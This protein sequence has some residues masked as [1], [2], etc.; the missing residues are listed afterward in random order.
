MRVLHLHSGNL[1]GGIERILVTLAGARRLDSRVSHHFA[2]C[3]AGRLA[4]ELNDADAVVLRL[5][6]VRVSRPQTV[7]SARAALLGHLPAGSFDRVVFHG[8]WAL[9]IF[10]PAVRRVGV[11]IVFW[12]HDVTTGSHWTERLA[13][14]VVPDLIICNSHFTS[15]SVTRL[16]RN[17]PA[18]V[19]YAPLI[20]PAEP[21][22]PSL[23]RRIR[24]ELDTAP[25]ATVILQASRCEAW[26]GHE[27]MVEALS[28]LR[29]IPG[30][31]WWLAG[32]A[33]RPSEAAFMKVLRDRVDNLGIERR[34]RW[35]GERRNV[36]SMMRASDLY[37]QANI[38]AEPFGLVFVEA[39]A[40]GLPIVTTRLGGALEVVTDACGL[41]VAPRDPAALA[42]ALRVALG[43]REC[44]RRLAEAAQA[45][46]RALCDPLARV[47]ELHDVLLAMD[48]VGAVA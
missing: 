25:E 35:L 20:L 28:R 47:T 19:I 42:S 24:E 40:A 18:A 16:Y 46:A 2:L 13:R 34:V 41:L 5:P 4:E 29:D 23:R 8:T 31:V 36:I 39:L 11:P 21:P 27:V 32:G 43:D 22:D 44:R 7:I 12:A 17:T 38:H 10:G 26:K 45:R 15:E 14:R 9:G 6:E 33:Q 1:Y 48:V 3:F 30:W 37:C